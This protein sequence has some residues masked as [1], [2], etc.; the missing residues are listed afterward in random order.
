MGCAW[1]EICESRI[2]SCRRRDYSGACT[3]NKVLSGAGSE[4]VQEGMIRSCPKK[5]IVGQGSE[6]VGGGISSDHPKQK[7]M[8]IWEGPELVPGR[9]IRSEQPRGKLMKMSGLFR[10]TWE[11]SELVPGC[12][13]NSD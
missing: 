11:G 4:L 13:M 8:T 10:C 1:C 5:R 9:G 2:S 12:G 6:L 3:S 7:F